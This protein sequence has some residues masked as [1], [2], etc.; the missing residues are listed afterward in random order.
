MIIYPKDVA[1]NVESNGVKLVVN[2]G[3]FDFVSFKVKG[4]HETNTL[5]YGYNEIGSTKSDFFILE[6]VN[7]IVKHIT[8][9]KELHFSVWGEEPG[10]A[11]IALIENDIYLKHYTDET[12][13]K[14]HENKNYCDINFIKKNFEKVVTSFAD[15]A[16]TI[17]ADVSTQY[18]RYKESRQLSAEEIDGLDKALRVFELAIKSTSEHL[19]LEEKKEFDEYSKAITFALI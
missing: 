18:G 4:N 12:W 10:F 3:W 17:Y 7:L 1:K 13:D 9:Q 11:Q 8:N 15:F 14:S 2:K 5:Y 19:S 16:K 6:I